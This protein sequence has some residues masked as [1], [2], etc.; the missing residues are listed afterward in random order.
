MKAKGSFGG[1][2]RAELIKRL[3][4][5]DRARFGGVFKVDCYGADG[6]LKWSETCHNI[7]T[8]EGLDD[9]LEQYFKGSSYTALW[10]AVPI[11]VITAPAAAN[12]YVNT[13]SDANLEFIGYSEGNRQV[14]TPGT[15]TSQSVDNSASKAVYSITATATIYG[16]AMVD[17]VT[18]GNNAASNIMYCRA[19]FA[20]SR[21]V[22][23]TDTLEITYTVTSADDGA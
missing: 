3:G 1:W 14:W 10:H 20:S 22:V 13:M 17:L 19:D 16:A 6:I 11:D 5:V 12:T 23:N 7:V 8:D 4:A 9:I 15:V 18:K 2:A 21:A